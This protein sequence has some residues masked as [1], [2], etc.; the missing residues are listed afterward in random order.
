MWDPGSV[1][2]A[3]EDAAYDMMRMMPDGWIYCHNSHVPD[4][5]A[6]EP[7]LADVATLK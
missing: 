2:D 7:A 6:A 3:L 4:V 5:L 1:F